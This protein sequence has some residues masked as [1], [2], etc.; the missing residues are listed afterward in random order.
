MF[1]NQKS[2]LLVVILMLLNIISLNSQNFNIDF[3]GIG[4]STLVDSV[5]VY[6]LTKSLQAKVNNNQ[7]LNLILSQTSVVDSYS[8]NSFI[9]ISPNPIITSADVSF[10]VP[11]HGNTRVN[12]YSID[13]K[14]LCLTSQYLEEGEASFQISLPRGL[15]LINVVG[16]SFNYTVKAISNNENITNPQIVF[17]GSEPHKQDIRY[18]KIMEYSNSIDLPY[19]IGD[20]LL[21]KGFASGKYCTIVTDRPNRSKTITFD[22]EECTDAS[23]N[24]YAVVNIGT[25]MWMAE[26]LATTKY[27]DG[28]TIYVENDNNSWVNMD[29]AGMCDNPISTKYGKLYNWYALSNRSN[30]NPRGW[31]IPSESDWMVFY[32]YLSSVFGTSTNM[33]KSIIMNSDWRKNPDSLF[34]GNNPELNNSIGYSALPAGSR[35]AYDLS[36]NLTGSY[37]NNSDYTGWWSSNEQNKVESIYMAVNNGKTSLMKGPKSLGL[38]VRCVRQS[39]Y[40]KISFKAGGASDSLDSIIVFNQTKSTFVKVAPKEDL[41][42]ITNPTQM[43]DSLLKAKIL[44]SVGDY[45]I[46]KA[47]SSIYCTIIPDLPRYNKT[48][49]INFFNC[50]DPDGNNYAVIDLGKKYWMAENLRTT[51]FQNGESIDE[52]ND[53]NLWAKHLFAAQCNSPYSNSIDRKRIYGRLYNWYAVTDK[54]NV[55]PKGWHIATDAEWTNLTDTLNLNISIN[56]AKAL[57]INTEWNEHTT[58]GVVGNDIKKNNSSGFGALPAG[59]RNGSKGTFS[60]LGTSAYWWTATNLKTSTNTAWYRYIYY[61]TSDIQRSDS[62]KKNGFSIRCVKD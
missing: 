18:N 58:L 19:S 47:Y 44:Y 17:N 41:Y 38:S 60:P 25:Q 50:S 26:N 57:A 54:R 1:N 32:R 8:S 23:R 3:A 55:A 28:T 15:F 24:N 49:N 40:A 52:I 35:G 30:I 62:N 10:P 39:Y 33:S 22:F 13:G 11:K 27:N 6:N 2:V 42:L 34:I 7:T 5:Q 56:L 4:T 36:G 61:D 37:F 31:E 12:V 29:Y 20:Q 43:E 45:L 48:I 51:K 53:N 46:Y 14:L 16:E 21:F 9:Q 59:W